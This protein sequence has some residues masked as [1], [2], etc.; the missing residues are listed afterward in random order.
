MISAREYADRRKRLDQKIGSLGVDAYLVSSRESI[1]Y[2]TGASYIPEERPFFMILFP[3]GSPLLIV[4]KLE[5][6]HMQKADIGEVLAYAEFP[7][8]KGAGWQ[9]VLS[10]CLKK[11]D[12]LGV[13]PSLSAEN[14]NKLSLFSPRVI[15]VV[16]QFRQIKSATEI[17]LI[18]Q[19][20]AYADLG[21]KKIMKASYKGATV[22]EIFSQARAVQTRVLKETIYD[23]MESS[24]LMASWPAPFSAQPH[25]I[26]RV[27]DRMGSGPLVG[28]SYLR[29]NGYAAEVERTYFHTP[30]SPEERAVYQHMLKAR[31]LAVSMVR[32]GVVCGEIDE[33]VYQFLCARGYEQYLL[34]RTGHGIGLGNHEGPYIARGSDDVLKEN[35]VISIEPGI[36]IPEIGGFRHSDT[37]LVTARGCEF[38]T[39]H[40]SDMDTLTLTAVKPLRRLMGKLISRSLG[41]K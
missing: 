37:V 9:D 27:D 12:T 39:H 32:P 29:V 7:A 10:N 28:L 23:P 17:E 21:M 40:P 25:G 4:P 18:R 26:P 35:M 2:L 31:E 5:Y 1:Y 20:A 13:E 41:L 11:T 16:D 30:P 33:A 24:F 34:H 38:L 8:P 19:T 22:L 14:L 6:A 15:P 3:K 36:Y